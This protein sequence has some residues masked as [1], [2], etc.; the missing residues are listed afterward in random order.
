M[1]ENTIIFKYIME[2]VIQ[3]KKHITDNNNNNNN[4]KLETIYKKN[5]IQYLREIFDITIH[6]DNPLKLYESI[7]M[8]SRTWDMYSISLLFLKLFRHP[9]IYFKFK[10]KIDT[11]YTKEPIEIFYNKLIQSLSSD[12]RQRPKVE[13]MIYVMDI[14]YQNIKW[15]TKER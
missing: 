5:L 7:S 10:Y 6:L 3:V 2:G 4:N 15:N 8:Y 1:Y 9:K 11:S 13:E 14:L 12:P